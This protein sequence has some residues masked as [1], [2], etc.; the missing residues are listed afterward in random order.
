M[1]V[2]AANVNSR[3]SFQIIEHENTWNIYI[4]KKLPCWSTSQNLNTLNATW[5]FLFATCAQK[6]YKTFLFFIF[7][8]WSFAHNNFFNSKFYLRIIMFMIIFSSYA[9][10]AY[11]YEW[12]WQVYLFVCLLCA[13][14][15]CNAHSPKITYESRVIVVAPNKTLQQQ[16]KQQK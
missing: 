6:W 1:Q 12:R 3:A 14:A 9:H 10:S 15:W 2:A 4:P 7:L 5:I 11:N 13:C 16:K 8:F